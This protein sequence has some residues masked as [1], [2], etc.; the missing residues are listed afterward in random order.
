MNTYSDAQLAFL[1][2]KYPTLS[3]IDLTAEFNKKF[4]TTKTVGQITSCLKN[5]K[6]RSGRSGHFGVDHSPWNTGTKGATVPNSTSFK[7]GSKP[8]NL[9]PLGH[10][11]ICQKDDYVL[12]KVAEPNPYTGAKTR[13]RHKHQVIWEQ[14]NGPIPKGMLVTFLDGNKRNFAIENLQLVDRSHLC[15]Y[16]KNRVCALPPEL[17]PAMKQVVNLKLKVLALSKKT[18]D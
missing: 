14:H 6:I 13:Y 3:R 9:K 12:I 18:E 11:R 2:D 1:R 16:N 17:V 5:N 8:A 15:R 10:E 7:K 4:K